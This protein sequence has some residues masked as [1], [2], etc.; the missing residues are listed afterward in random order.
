MWR[1]SPSAN[2]N[3]LLCESS[4]GI[5]RILVEEVQWFQMSLARSLAKSRLIIFQRYERDRWK[6]RDTAMSMSWALTSLLQKILICCP[7][8]DGLAE[9]WHQVAHFWI[10]NLESTERS[11][12]SAESPDRC[13]SFPFY[14]IFWSRK[15]ES[16]GVRSSTR[17][18]IQSV[19]L[20]PNK[21][22][23][24]YFDNGCC[25]IRER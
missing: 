6:R 2:L 22:E 7:N 12:R 9:D 10:V 1:I 13:D 23:R 25:I 17:C 11:A 3:H 8:I 4:F 19:L 21:S 14:A 15:L 16:C 18:Q 24:A 5:C 20:V